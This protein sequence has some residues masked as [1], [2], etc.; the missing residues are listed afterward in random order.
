MEN[1]T[2]VVHI[3]KSYY[4]HSSCRSIEQC[5]HFKCSPKSFQLSGASLLI[6]TM[7]ECWGCYWYCALKKFSACTS[8]YPPRVIKLLQRSGGFSVSSLF[9]NKI[10]VWVLHLEVAVNFLCEQVSYWPWYLCDHIYSSKKNSQFL[11]F[12][13]LLISV[14]ISFAPIW[15]LANTVITDIGQNPQADICI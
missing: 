12:A 14:G 11:S 13:K 5:M 10:V 9:N 1:S 2:A 15:N 7:M 3:Y 4:W 6:T 8:L